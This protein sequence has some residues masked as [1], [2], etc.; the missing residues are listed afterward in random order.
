[1]STQAD[2]IAKNLAKHRAAVKRTIVKRAKPFARYEREERI[3]LQSIGQALIDTSRAASKEL[4]RARRTA[5]T[6][7]P[8]ELVQNSS[9]GVDLVRHPRLTQ[10][11]IDALAKIRSEN[12]RANRSAPQPTPLRKAT[13]LPFD[14]WMLRVSL[15]AQGVNGPVTGATV[16]ITTSANAWAQDWRATTNYD[17]LVTALALPIEIA[18]TEADAKG[19]TITLTD[20]QIEARRRAKRLAIYKSLTV[21]TKLPKGVVVVRPVQQTKETT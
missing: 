15:V 11:E 1:M 21:P 20:D 6:G 10:A 4:D 9:T 13:E 2:I 17:R 7:G 14:A 16:Y 12:M 5:I 18:P 8:P 3:E 19:K